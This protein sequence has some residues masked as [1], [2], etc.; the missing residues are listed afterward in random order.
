[1][2]QHL[3]ETGG[4]SAIARPLSLRL[5]ICSR[6]MRLW[7]SPSCALALAVF[8][9]FSSSPRSRSAT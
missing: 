6:T 1:M 2:L 8:S 7:A 3:S 4:A 5:H 9:A